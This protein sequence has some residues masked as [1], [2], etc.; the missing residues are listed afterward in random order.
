ML[1]RH[2]VRPHNFTM[3]DSKKRRNERTVREIITNSLQKIFVSKGQIFQKV[4]YVCNILSLQ[5]TPLYLS[6]VL[7]NSVIKE[8]D[9][10]VG[11][12]YLYGTSSLYFHQSSVFIFIVYTNVKSVLYVS[13]LVFPSEIPVISFTPAAVYSCRILLFFNK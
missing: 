8:G 7:L 2:V 12:I 5:K 11:V 1:A 13:Y 10:Y 4:K 6:E 3:Y 9:R